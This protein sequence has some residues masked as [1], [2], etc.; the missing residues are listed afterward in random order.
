MS[1]GAAGPRLRVAL[2]GSP[3]FAL[4]CLER[5]RRDHDLQLVVAQPD[6]PAGRGLRTR[7]PA[8]AAWARAAGVPV[9]QPERLRGNDAFLATLRD[10]DLDV[11]VSAAYG[12]L[13]PTALLGVPREGV[14]NVHASLLPRHRGAAP[15]QWAL[16]QGD[17]ETGVTIMQTDA[18][19]D[20]GAIRLERRTPIGPDEHAAELMDRLAVLGAEALGDA[21]ALLALGRLPSRP[22]DDAAATLAPRLTRADGRI[23]WDAPSAAVVARHRGVTPWPGS[24]FV[25]ERDGREEIVK[26]HA[27]RAGDPSDRGLPPGEI[28]AVDDAGLHVATADGA[29]VLGELQSPG[30]PRLPAAVWARGARLAAGARLPLAP[31]DASA[32]PGAQE[33][34][35]G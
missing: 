32:Q 10:L 22:Q 18:G 11:A 27:L 17:A 23:R 30:R 4:P 15:V 21:L 29:V 25:L 9:A 7:T 34:H 6:K 2:F 12:K 16:I 13:L 33:V 31:L 20:T 14:L 35:G 3:A 28:A 26:V 19:L 24:S 5:L 1:A 8:T